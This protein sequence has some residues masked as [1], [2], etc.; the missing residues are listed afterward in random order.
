MEGSLP[1]S[2][3]RSHT[4]VHTHLLIP[5]SSSLSRRRYKN[6]S[7]SPP[8]GIH[9]HASLL[10]PAPQ[11]ANSYS[12][13][14]PSPSIAPPRAASAMISRLLAVWLLRIAVVSAAAQKRLVAVGAAT[15]M[16][17]AAGVGERPGKKTFMEEM[18]AAAMRLHSRDQ[19]RHGEKEVPLEPPV[20]TWDPT[21]G[22][23]IRF[24]VDSKLVFDTLEAI[25]DR[26]AIPWSEVHARIT[27]LKAAIEKGV[28]KIIL[29]TDSLIMKQALENDPHRLAEADFGIIESSLRPKWRS[30]AKQLAL[31]SKSHGDYCVY[32]PADQTHWPS[33]GQSTPRALRSGANSEATPVHLYDPSH[34]LEYL[35]DNRTHLPGPTCQSNRR[36]IASPLSL[37]HRLPQPAVPIRS[38]RLFYSLHFLLLIVALTLTLPP[39][40]PALP[41]HTSTALH[42]HRQGRRPS[43]SLVIGAFPSPARN[44]S[45]SARYKATAAM[46]PTPASLA[47]PRALSLLPTPRVSSG[48]WNSLSS[49]S[50]AARLVTGA[51]SVSV[52]T[53]QR[54]MVA[55]A[56]ATEM[57]PAASGEEGSKPFV[58]EMRAVAMKLHTKDQAREGEKE[59]QAPPVA[60]WEPSVEGYLR[61]LVDSR[62]VFQTLED[63]VE[64][65]AVSEKILNKKE[66][67][68]YRWEGN[69]SE[70]LQNSWSRE[71]KNH[72][73]EETEKSF[74]YSGE[75]LRH[76]FT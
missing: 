33:I 68:F 58:D 14:A 55:A 69:L 49:V 4:S 8:H 32:A 13:P 54:R 21:V 5:P 26:A 40:R 59:P 23:F 29:E 11:Q 56:A 71:E 67:E 44:P 36:M 74:A 35:T 39:P 37:R 20:A 73:L 24:L 62:L 34:S 46:A 10:S 45:T 60:K 48:R 19:S 1:C 12:L 43:L 22:G 63:I 15:R 72:C 70:L 7:P 64:R 17:S 9:P 30:Q 76:I 3:R 31:A 47:A 41:R 6:P 25:V 18:R 51:V 42:R 52:V 50:V 53:A 75:L 38:P 28:D 27:W 61:F 16:A 57:A 65:A 2:F 66:L